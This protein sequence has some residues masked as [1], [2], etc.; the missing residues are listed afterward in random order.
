MREE[1]DGRNSI[2]L[3]YRLNASDLEATSGDETRVPRAP[4]DES[5]SES[6]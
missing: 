3:G 5:L 1:D 4:D 2:C 6:F